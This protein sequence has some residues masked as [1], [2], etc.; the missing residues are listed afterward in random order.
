MLMPVRKARTAD[1]V[2][3]TRCPSYASW[4]ASTSNEKMTSATHAWR[5]RISWTVRWGMLA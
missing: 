2:A 3:S 5:R 4:H 1:G